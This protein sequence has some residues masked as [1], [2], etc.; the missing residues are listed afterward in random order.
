MLILH[1]LQLLTFLTLFCIVYTLEAINYKDLKLYK[2][3]SQE[4]S[5]EVIGLYSVYKATQ[6]VK[7]NNEARQI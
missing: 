3:F 5:E 1:T 7:L 2:V 6:T 4:Q